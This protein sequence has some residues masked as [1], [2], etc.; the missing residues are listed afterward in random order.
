MQAD[1]RLLLCLPLRGTAWERYLALKSVQI[2]ALGAPAVDVCHLQKKKGGWE[3]N[4]DEN[5]EQKITA[6]DAGDEASSC[7]C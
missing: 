4:S 2:L 3:T 1:I 6:P 5:R 7:S